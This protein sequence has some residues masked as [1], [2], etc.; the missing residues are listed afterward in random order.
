MSTDIAAQHPD[1]LSVQYS[2]ITKNL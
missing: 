1:H 2:I